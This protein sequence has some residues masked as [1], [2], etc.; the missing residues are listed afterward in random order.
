METC[1]CGTQ[2]KDGTE[3]CP[4]CLRRP[5]DKDGLVAELNDTF[6]KTTWA[7]PERLTKPSPPS[8]FSRWRA[9]PLSFGPRVKIALTV[10]ISAYML[11]TVVPLAPW[12]WFRH[13]EG[14]SPARAF[15]LFEI[16]LTIVVG[17]ALLRAIWKKS[18][19]E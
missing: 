9:G 2:L 4:V 8:V 5:L 12:G 18:R 11:Y 13:Q 3:W 15:G 7:T 16:F 10:V 1:R 6:R 14:Y 19:V 17:A